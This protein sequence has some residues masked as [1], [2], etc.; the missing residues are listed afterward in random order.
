MSWKDRP[1]PLND[2]HQKAPLARD[3]I[4]NALTRLFGEVEL[5][6]EFHREWNGAWAVH[7]TIRGIGII[8][9]LLMETPQGAILPIPRPFPDTW[10]GNTAI[11]ASDDS[12]WTITEQDELVPFG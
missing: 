6:Y 5:D 10:R 1:V 2:L 7:T 8:D 12:L 9:I 11:L 3:C 4:R